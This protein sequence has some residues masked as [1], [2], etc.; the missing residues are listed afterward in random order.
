[1]STAS[2]SM[3][4]STVE[5]TRAQ[6]LPARQLCAIQSHS[7]AP[8][9]PLAMNRPI[10]TC[11]ALLTCAV[12]RVGLCLMIAARVEDSVVMSMTMPTRLTATPT[13]MTLAARRTDGGA[14]AGA[15]SRG[16]AP[17]GYGWYIAAS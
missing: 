6:P 9:R 12:V 1:M 5:T 13:Y 10:S 7:A 4:K 16:S 2:V 17:P 3:A 14:L 15:G 11:S 8:I